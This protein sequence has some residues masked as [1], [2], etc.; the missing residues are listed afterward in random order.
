MQIR[1]FGTR[2][3]EEK[4][5]IL[6]K[7]GSTDCPGIASLCMPSDIARLM[8]QAYDCDRLCEEAMYL[9][10]F[11][12]KM[13]L[14]GVF[15]LAKGVADACP[16]GMREIFIRVLLAGAVC[17]ILVHN[18]PSGDPAPSEADRR[19]TGK[20]VSLSQLMNL[21]LLDHVII[22]ENGA[23]F[24]FRESGLMPQKKSEWKF[25]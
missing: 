21:P 6:V 23:F 12:Q 7:E 4:T 25:T 17:F 15:P 18:H 22:G 3:S 9:L 5:N 13:H 11:T 8:C 2:L 20:L 14:I 24:S 1:T 19:L 10:C 16:C